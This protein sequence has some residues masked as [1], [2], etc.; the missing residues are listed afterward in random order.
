MWNPAAVTL[1][2]AAMTALVNLLDG[3]GKHKA[4]REPDSV[5]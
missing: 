3:D 4:A 1:V 2:A 5:K